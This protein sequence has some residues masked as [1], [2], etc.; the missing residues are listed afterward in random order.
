MIADAIFPLGCRCGACGKDAACELY[1]E[2][3]HAERVIER[4]RV[5]HR[6]PGRRSLAMVRASRLRRCA[7]QRNDDP[8]MRP[9]AQGLPSP[10]QADNLVLAIAISRR[11]LLCLASITGP[12]SVPAWSGRRPRALGFDETVHHVLNRGAL[13]P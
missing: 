13:S 3:G 11:I 10:T 2:V 8:L 7:V 1:G 6:A 4:P 9:L 5:H 12:T